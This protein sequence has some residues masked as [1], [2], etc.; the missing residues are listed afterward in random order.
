M[1]PGQC[2]LGASRGCYL[3]LLGGV[4]QGASRK[5]F[6]TGCYLSAS[7][8]CYL[9]ASMGCYLGAS[10]RCY[11]GVSRGCYLGVSRGC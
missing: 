3:V 11:L 8:G 2:C 10:M 5:M 1:L 6:P 9:G 7:R 4:I